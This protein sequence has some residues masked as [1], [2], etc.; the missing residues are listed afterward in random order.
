MRKGAG[1]RPS[2][3]AARLVA[4]LMMAL[5]SFSF[6]AENSSVTCDN[7]PAWTGFY[8]RFISE[9]GRV[10]DP[11]T[12]PPGQ[13]TSEGQAYAMF[14]ALVANDRTGFSRLLSWTE[15]NLA[16]GDLTAHLPAW[17]WGRKKNDKE[18]NWGVLDVNAASDADLWMVYTLGEAGRLWQEPKYTALSQLLAAR[19]LREETVDVPSLGRTLLPGPQGFQPQP[20]TYRLNPSYVPLAV[21]RRLAAQNPQPEWKGLVASSLAIIEQSSSTGY[22]P[23]WVLHQDGQFMPD[24]QTQAIGS[25]DAIRVYLWAGMLPQDDPVRATLLKTLAPAAQY[26]AAHGAPFLQADARTGSAS[27]TGPAGF[28]AALLPFLAASGLQEAVHQQRLRVETRAPIEQSDNYY[29]Q[30]LTLFGLGWMDGHYRFASD[31]ALT[32]NWTCDAR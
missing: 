23:D 4:L 12:T 3:Q 14:F 29:D 25:Y 16:S 2:W 30:V 19:V 8:K 31:G 18:K 15:N 9:D 28:S 13:T 5:S 21:M 6:A 24:A 20:D 11:S 22:A 27:G 10:I 1:S 7:W 32:T 17:Q 26:V